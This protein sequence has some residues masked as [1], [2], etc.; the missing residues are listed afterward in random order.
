MPMVSAAHHGRRPDAS[1][2]DLV[3]AMGEANGAQLSPR[4]GRVEA[5]SHS[6][7]GTV[8]LG[9]PGSCGPRGIGRR[10]ADGVAGMVFGAG[11]RPDSS[12]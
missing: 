4:R 11:R 10:R 8:R 2:D 1:L 7:R 5:K 6:R 12:L 3:R 9:A